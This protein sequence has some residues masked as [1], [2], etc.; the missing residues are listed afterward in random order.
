MQRLSGALRRMST[1]SFKRSDGTE[2]PSYLTGD[3]KLGLVVLSEWWGLTDNIKAMGDRLAKD[4]GA[5]VLVP[6]LYR[7]KQTQDAEEANHL[8]SNLDFPLAVKD[9]EAC[10]LFLKNEKKLAKVGVTGFCMGGALTLATTVLVPSVDAGAPF[11][12]ICPP[13]LADPA[14]CKKPIQ[15]HFGNEDALEGFSDPKSADALEAGLKK[16]G[17][18]LE[19]HRYDACGHA[20]CNVDGPNYNKEAADLAL[21][22]L[23]EFMQAKLA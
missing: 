1:I 23:K 22:R 18:E 11:Y 15:C 13:A 5:T 2:V 20:F 21:G 17:C 7:G 16:S 19:F 12:G 6:D 10:A 14:N 4:L 8:M 9:A 3:G